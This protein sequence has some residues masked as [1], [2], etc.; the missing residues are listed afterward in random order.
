LPGGI[1]GWDELHQNLRNKIKALHPVSE[2]LGV[3]EKVP[4]TYESGVLRQIFNELKAI[5]KAV[6]K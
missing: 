4:A 5:R 1:F 6:E 3:T 2:A